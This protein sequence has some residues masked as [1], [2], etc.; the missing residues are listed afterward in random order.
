MS[1]NLKHLF[2]KHKNTNKGSDS[3]QTRICIEPL[4]DKHFYTSTYP[5]VLKN[6]IDPLQHYIEHGAN[7][8]RWPN[9]F[10][11]T[12][13]YLRTNIDVA[14]A[15]IN[16]L[17]HFLENGATE[18][19]NPS[20]EFDVNFYTSSYPDVAESGVNPLLHYIKY[21]MKEGRATSNKNKELPIH[22]AQEQ[23]LKPVEVTKNISTSIQ[24][25]FD[26]EYYISQYPEISNESIT[27][28]EH[29]L[30]I[31]FK[32]RKKPNPLFDTD[33]Y[34]TKYK[35]VAEHGINPLVHYIL[36]GA[37]EG[38]WA[39]QFFSSNYYLTTYK[40]VAEAGLNPLFHFLSS[41]AK[42]GRNPSNKFNV[43]FYTSNYPDVIASGINPLV[44][45]I[46]FGM[47]EGRL[48]VSQN[49]INKNSNVYIPPQDLLPW[50][51]PLNLEINPTLECTPYLN[52][53]VPGLAMKHM[54]GG[55]NTALNLAGRLAGAG[56][57]IR[58]CSTNAPLDEDHT[59]FWEHVCRLADLQTKPDN[60]ELVDMS[61]RLKEHQIG[62]NDIFMATAWWTAQ[63]A[64][65]AIKMTDNKTFIYLIQDYEPILH[66]ASTPQVLA[67]ETYSEDHIGVINTEL[68]HEFLIKQKIGR[69]SDEEFAKNALVFN[70]AVDRTLFYP[71]ARKTSSKKKFL[72][73]A[74]PN[75]GLRNLFEIGVAA[76]QKC[77]F[78]GIL[79]PNSW[80]FIGMGENFSPVD[81]GFGCTLRAAQWQD[82][83]GYAKQMREADILLSL[84][85]SPHPSY[86]PLEMALCGR[87]VITNVYFNKSHERLAAFSQNIIGVQPTIDGVSEGIKQALGKSTSKN[88]SI[89]EVDELPKTWE[90]AFEN[91]IPQL[92][93]KLLKLF[94]AP[95]A[96]KTHESVIFDYTKPTDRA[97]GFRSWPKNAYEVVKYKRQAERNK[98]YNAS[99]KNLF[100]F[101]TTVWNTPSEYL[102]E[103]AECVF[104]QDCGTDFEWIILDNGSVNKDTIDTMARIATH[105]CVKFLRVK[106]NLGIIG[107]MRH[108]LGIAKNQYIIPL[109]S[110]DL[111][112]PDCVRILAHY[113]RE[114]NYPAL[115]YTDEDKIY[116][117][118]YR[119]AYD[120]PD[121]DPVLFFH[122]CYIAHLGCIDRIKAIKLGVYDNDDFTG[123]HDYDTFTRF[124]LAGHEPLHIPEVVYSWRMHTGSTAS[125]ITSKDYISSSQKKLLEK[126][127][128]AR[129]SGFSISPSPLFN[130]TPDWR[131]IR[132]QAK[133]KPFVT[134][135]FG[136]GEADSISTVDEIKNYLIQLPSH[137][138]SKD[139]LS[140]IE[141]IEDGTLI[142]LRDRASKITDI[143]WPWEAMGL[144]DLFPDTVM[145]GGIVHK[146]NHII[147]APGHFGFGQ[148]CES[149]DIGRNLS[150]PGYF[151][152]M[153]KPHSVASVPMDHVVIETAFLRSTLQKISNLELNIQDLSSWL[154]AIAK[155]NEKRIIFTPFM[156]AEYADTSPVRHKTGDG[157]WLAFR[158][159]FP[160]L[161]NDTSLLSKGLSRAI[162]TRY[163]SISPSEQN[164]EALALQE[165][166]ISY[167]ERIK[168][169]RLIRQYER[170]ESVAC[171]NIKI[172]LMT[173]V[174]S[175]TDA[176]YLIQLI[177][178][179]RK[180]TSNIYEWVILENGS[181]SDEVA[182]VLR[183]AKLNLPIKLYRVE[184]NLGIQG[185]IAYCLKMAEAEFVA[186][187]DADDLLESDA[188][189]CIKEAIHKTKADIFYTDEDHI[190]NN[191]L[192][193]PFRRGEFDP[194][195]NAIDSYIFHFVVFNRLK[196]IELGLYSDKG[197]EYCHDWDTITKFA[198]SNSKIHHVPH[199][200]Y[201]WRMHSVSTSGSGQSNTGTHD[202]VE[203]MLN[204][205][206]LSKASPDL[207]EVAQ[208]PLDRGVPQLCIKRKEINP[209]PIFAI[210]ISSQHLTPKMSWCSKSWEALKGE[211]TLKSIQQENSSLSDT[212]IETVNKLDNSIKHIMI[213]SDKLEI[214]SSSSIFEAMRVFEMHSSVG[215]LSGRVFDLNNQISEVGEPLF[216]DV[217]SKPYNWLRLKP[218][219]TG[220]F[221][222]TLKCQRTKSLTDNLFFVQREILIK[223]LTKH[224]VYSISD[225]SK[226]ISNESKT[227]EYI[228]AYSPLIETRTL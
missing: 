160:N 13:F 46:N 36:S 66:P 64:K 6:N 53:L 11:D 170:Y 187:V 68:L 67:E 120:K 101:L 39:N 44:H 51:S 30:T 208:F 50:F 209:L 109:D 74:R 162:D 186:P 139:L 176:D 132:P 110:D 2:R 181:I 203:W 158:T 155:L 99:E 33:Y 151:A 15:Q 60:A 179:I 164:N 149:L 152:Q 86:P 177:D 94:G 157:N 198:K 126:F 72:F 144:F 31:G 3:H 128:N 47:F 218:K 26:E 114:N 178:S 182:N 227:G 148:G 17:E 79:D 134:L 38:R 204:K 180:Q 124:Y 90:N 83:D 37:S 23:A 100:S 207:Y 161:L 24:E 98:I 191:E 58:F 43:H 205:E 20:E 88:V 133:A 111:L 45:Y 54:S 185:A 175:K 62:K 84:M 135:C 143:E 69:Y 137:A 117:G 171:K 89:I 96:L 95:P 211:V 103:L 206:I 106:D 202:S 136:E 65:Y 63:M 49:K 173:S 228:C 163:N 116:E 224:T 28:L 121:W 5:D 27:P 21:G 9:Q 174:Y 59:P 92:K 93:S 212:I 35:D 113:L 145:V 107:G 7:E 70:P 159:L 220:E 165:L 85:L 76:L 8:G 16:P 141:K 146:N 213:I 219:S 48:P 193:A 25:L 216:R 210:T 115:A 130:N 75:N 153:F 226:L 169:E 29:Y 189:E 147:A 215:A 154:G 199:I 129:G 200:L 118:S 183:S 140:I 217:N 40:D 105:P 56:I 97:V 42:E 71:I 57:P 22:D 61:A 156:R 41:G 14:R 225:I 78:D 125:N 73:Y 119:D 201:H 223:I 19:R 122:S 184:K 77:I 190:I 104:T 12:N 123:C 196:A 166:E 108:V 222:L 197:A 34:L 192:R 214:P 102:E 10:F 80:E 91:I 55:P 195:L 142:H 1:F 127:L 112:T 82:L 167:G 194:I 221:A 168:S 150:D 87:S 32:E 188:I 4:F 138:T 131:L 52:V 172:G 18:G 81:L